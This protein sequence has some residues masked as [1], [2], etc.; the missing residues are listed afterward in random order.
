MKKVFVV[1]IAAI[2]VLSVNAQIRIGVKA[3]LNLANINGKDAGSPKINPS[4]NVG[5]FAEFGVTDNFALEAGLA[6]SGKGAKETEENMTVTLSPLYLEIPINANLKIDLGAAKLLIFAGPYVG[7]GVGGKIKAEEGSQSASQDITYG[8]DDAS[9]LKRID[10]GLNFGA[11]I[12]ISKIQIRAQYGLGLTNIASDGSDVKNAVIGIS[13]GYM[14][15][16]K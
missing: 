1:A 13:V 6:L 12:E 10:V 4:Y 16:G 8:S 5:G 15:G 3:G 2:M 7:I 14:F 11:G 9:M